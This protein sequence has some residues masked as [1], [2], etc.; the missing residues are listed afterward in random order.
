MVLLILRAHVFTLGGD[1][2]ES[3]LP[4]IM[5][6]L[7]KNNNNSN[8]SSSNSTS[9]SFLAHKLNSS[10]YTSSSSPAGGGSALAPSSTVK[11]KKK[12]RTLYDMAGARISGVGGG[13]G[14]TSG[15]LL[16]G[17]GMN[18]CL[19]IFMMDAAIALGCVY[20]QCSDVPC[21]VSMCSHLRDALKTDVSAMPCQ[22]L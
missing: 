20:V 18:L 21:H 1:D 13:V 19:H 14:G 17:A 15:S 9:A 7:G 4:P 3:A 8:N 11:R 2:D 16:T 6:I 10:V 12:S 22:H 5:G